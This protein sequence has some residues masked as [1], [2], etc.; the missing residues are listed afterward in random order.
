MR[1]GEMEKL[2]GREEF[3]EEETKGKAK[4][5][6]AKGELNGIY[7]TSITQTCINQ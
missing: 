6:Y 2:N 1:T 5:K 4:V 7:I 3:K